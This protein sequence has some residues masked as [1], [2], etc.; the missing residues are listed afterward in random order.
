MFFISLAILLGPSSGKFQIVDMMNSS[1]SC[2]GISNYPIK[3]SDYTGGVIGG[4]PVFCGGETSGRES[5]AC[6]A[7]NKT[8][9]SWTLLADLAVPRRG[10]AGAVVNGALWVTGGVSSTY[11][12]STEFIFPNGTRLDGPDLPEGRLNHCLVTLHD[13]Q[14][15]IIGTEHPRR[16][17]N[18]VKI[19]DPDT[20]TFS[21][22]PDMLFSRSRLGVHF[23]L[24]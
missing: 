2:A 20:K 22:G 17:K 19:F 7:Y 1:S 15:M 12:K 4:M 14:V 8:L 18:S 16:F 11:H 5:S 24:R 10:V 6:Y 13:N 3:V 23:C 9:A 21:K